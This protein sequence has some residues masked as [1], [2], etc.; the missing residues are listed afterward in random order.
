MTS[1]IIRFFFFSVN[2][3]SKERTKSSLVIKEQQ[4][5]EKKN[6]NISTSLCIPKTKQ[7]QQKRGGE[8]GGKQ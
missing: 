7:K 4:K 2:R 5:G 1:Q 6:L 8:K 3:R